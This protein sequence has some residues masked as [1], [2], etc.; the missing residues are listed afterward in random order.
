M[1]LVTGATGNIGRRVVEGLALEGRPVRA[2]VRDPGAVEAFEAMGVHAYVGDLTRA[3]D[4]QGAL[5]GVTDLLCCHG[6]YS[7]ADSDDVIAVDGEATVALI[8]EARAAGVG[9]C[10]LLSHLG[11][12]RLNHSSRFE[13]KRRAEA[14]LLGANG[15][16]HTILRLAPLMSTLTNLPAVHNPG[17]HGSFIIFGRGENRISPLAPGDVAT[18]VRRCPR[19]EAA[20]GRVLEVGGPET[21]TW[22][23]LPGIFERAYQTSLATWRLPLWTLRLARLIAGWISASRADRLGYYVALF[24]NDL[25]AE[26]AEICALLGVELTDFESYL[27]DEEAAV[28][29]PESDE[30]PREPTAESIPTRAVEGARP[31]TPLQDDDLPEPPLRA[32]EL[33]TP[34]AAPADAELDDQPEPRLELIGQDTG[35]GWIDPDAPAA[36]Q[37]D[38][39]DEPPPPDDTPPAKRPKVI[40]GDHVERSVIDA[41]EEEPAG[42]SPA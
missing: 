35:I 30:H 5:H 32:T 24:G 17:R 1:I 36:Q 23:E 12:D 6:A 15:M 19:V 4:R 27:A 10:L 18:M 22:N 26:P 7:G 37:V 21:Y 2:L 38:F 33:A 25:A 31:T 13:A 8:E 39:G 42:E 29:P 34:P 41:T 9:Y 28:A 20:R 3:A 40:R 16:A 11:A 14:A